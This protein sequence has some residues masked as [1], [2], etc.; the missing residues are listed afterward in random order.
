MESM[1]YKVGNK[2]DDY[3]DSLS[4]TLSL[5]ELRSDIVKV[6][7]HCIEMN[8]LSSPSPVPNPSP[9]FKSRGKGLGLGLTL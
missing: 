4:Q 3:P 6:E 2:M 7:P 1:E 8:Q 9:K 5:P